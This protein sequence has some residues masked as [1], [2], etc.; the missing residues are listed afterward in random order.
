MYAQEDQ[1]SASFWALVLASPRRLKISRIPDNLGQRFPPAGPVRITV[2]V[3]VILTRQASDLV[4]K[5]HPNS[6]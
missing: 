4:N 5:A 6:S 3:K 1:S 2:S